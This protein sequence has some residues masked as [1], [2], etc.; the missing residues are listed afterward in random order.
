[1][2]AVQPGLGA[3]PSSAARGAPPEPHDAATPASDPHPFDADRRFATPA[4]LLVKLGGR[5]QQ[6]AALPAALAALCAA[7]PG[8]VVLVHGG[9]DEVS[10]LQRAMG[11]EPRFVGGRRVT[12]ER[13]VELVRMALSGTSNKRLVA[14]LL[15]AEVPAV[16]VSGEDAEL[17]LA[18]VHHPA[19]G[20]VGRVRRVDPRL[21]EVL[22]A[23][24]YVPVVSPLG[25]DAEGGGPLN[26][27]GDDA[28]AA[29]AAALDVDE[30]L[31]LADVPGVL[32][33]A[34]AVIPALDADA[35]RAL[36]AAGVA[37]GGMAAK[38]EA[39]LAAL[40]GGVRRARIGGLGALAD[41]AAGTQVT[42]A[43]AGAPLA[44]PS[45]A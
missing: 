11:L 12:G 33:D 45:V 40:A 36:V 22:L 29:V 44:H 4:R 5:V 8:S 20:R 38:L 14:A 41:A 24:G 9:G 26:V 17:I 27:N 34:G 1:M 31:F 10:A 16:G 2:S 18:E 43:P 37:V 42:L 28:A 30:V 6:D 15:S 19:F 3:P 32:D 7:R 35:A 23:A 13:D 25:R 39:A 21:L